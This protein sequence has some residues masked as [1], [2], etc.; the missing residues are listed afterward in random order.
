MSNIHRISDFQNDSSRHHGHQG[1]G[2]FAMNISGPRHN[3]NV[4]LLSN[5]PSASKYHLKFFRFWT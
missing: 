4:S 2:M 5:N 1:R 3:D